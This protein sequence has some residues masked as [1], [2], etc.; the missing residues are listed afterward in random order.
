[1]FP[2]YSLTT[3]MKAAFHAGN[4]GCGRLLVRI[5]LAQKRLNLLRQELADGGRALRRKRL[6][7]LCRFYAEAHGY[8]L[9]QGLRLNPSTRDH[10]LHVLYVESRSKHSFPLNWKRTK[11]I[12]AE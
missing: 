3:E 6:R 5:M 1:M 12:L 2:A 10:L 8:V 4:R 11:E 9:L 7:P